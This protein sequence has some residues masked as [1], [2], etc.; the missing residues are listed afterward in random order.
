VALIGIS[1]GEQI[2]HLTAAYDRYVDLARRR[3]GG[4][5]VSRLGSFIR[6]GM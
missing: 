1:L 3:F 6:A 4:H 5:G 2:A